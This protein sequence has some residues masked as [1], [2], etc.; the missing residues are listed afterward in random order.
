MQEDVGTAIAVLDELEADI[1]RNASLTQKAYKRLEE[2]IVTLALPPGEVLSELTLSQRLKIGRTPV[3]EALHRL[4]REGLVI[5]LARRGVV[6]S[7]LDIA[8]QLRLLE[9]RRELERLMATLAAK[10]ATKS[11]RA[12]FRVLA[13]GMRSVAVSGDELQ[14]MR[15]DRQVNLLLCRASRNEYV[16]DAMTLTHGLSRRFWFKHH[17]IAEELGLCATLH[18]NLMDALASGCEE[19]AVSASDDLMD[20]IEQFTRSTL[21]K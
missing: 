18:A 2:L 7:E 19:E 1:E 12:A 20:Y 3:R 8:K 16:A 17:N 6:V 11:E 9:V 4:C 5:I 21:D 14:F 13:D 10:R 15:L